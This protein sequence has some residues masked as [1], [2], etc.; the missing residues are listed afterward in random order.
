MLLAVQR[1]RSHQLSS[2]ELQASCRLQG[3]TCFGLEGFW[4]Q[5][6]E[7]LQLDSEFR[8]VEVGAWEVSRDQCCGLL[9]ASQS[10]LGCL[11]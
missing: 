8:S 7:S 3:P 6:L 9:Q 5:G 11:F 1:M 10:K 4:V 2:A